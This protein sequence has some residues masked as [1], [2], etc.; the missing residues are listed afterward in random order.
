MKPIKKVEMLVLLA[1]IWR[2]VTSRQHAE[3]FGMGVDVLPS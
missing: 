2:I 1:K 3:A